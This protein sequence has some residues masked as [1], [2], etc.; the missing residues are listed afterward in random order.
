[1]AVVALIA[2]IV[3][4]HQPLANA[5]V[6]VHH[7]G[8]SIAKMLRPASALNM[9]QISQGEAQKAID[10]VVATL[11]KDVAAIKDLGRLDKVTVILGYG[12]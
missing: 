3:A 9:A 6:L 5:F 2:L 10:A 12:R 7:G 1:M 8:R 4:T 11:R